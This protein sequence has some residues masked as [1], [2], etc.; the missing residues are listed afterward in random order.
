MFGGRSW[1]S[2]G[3]CSR[4]RGVTPITRRDMVFLAARERLSEG[5][6]DRA[7]ALWTHWRLRYG[8]DG[9]DGE[10]SMA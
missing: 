4:R 5:S 9:H 10:H 8:S 6:S 1:S 7:M 2:Q 3:Y